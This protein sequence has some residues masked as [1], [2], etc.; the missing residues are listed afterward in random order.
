M[1]L[2]SALP[3]IGLLLTGLT[4]CEEDTPSSLDPEPIPVRSVEVEL[5]WS[6]F[7]E[8]VEVYRGYGSPA[9]LGRV[10][11]AHDFD[12]ALDSRALVRPAPYPLTSV[13]LDSTGT[14]RIDSAFVFIAG[15]L[16]AKVDTLAGDLPEVPVELHAGI[17]QS[18]WD[19]ESASWDVAVDTFGNQLDWLEAGADPVTSL[20]LAT[21]DPEAGDSIVWNLDSLAVASI[22]SVTG[23]TT[24]LRL[25]MASAGQRLA[26][27]EVALRLDTRPNLN[28][29]T[30]ISLDVGAL[31]TTF[32]YTPQPAVDD[33]A[34][35]VGGAPSYRT[36]IRVN[37]PRELNGPPALCALIGC[38]FTLRESALNNARL[39]LTSAAVDPGFQPVD[40]LF[41]DTRTVLDAS[42]LPKS[43]LST[44]LSG[45]LGVAVAPE[46]FEADGG[47]EVS[48][49]VTNFVQDLLSDDAA[50]SSRRSLALL[51]LFEP[52]GL[53]LGS[54]RA[55]GTPGEP[56]LRLILT[57]A[58]TVVLP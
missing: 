31:E 26:L 14:N 23:S 10:F 47:I 58:D 43:P 49:P 20:G 7:G 1:K 12:G 53:V 4:A 56:R 32:I 15:R 2:T 39:L 48:F 17:L 11:I 13:V 27:T 24:G 57:V 18:S 50:V 28:P 9:D 55:P 36:V 42:L 54:F 44:S 35:R 38:P 52:L 45:G 34:L 16:V 33:G 22:G 6:Q 5:P 8:S 30:V 46:T 25:D 29:D 51:T 41:L 21:W 3:L 37:L 40:T 19:A